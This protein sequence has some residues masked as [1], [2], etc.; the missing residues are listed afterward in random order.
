[1]SVDLLG[2]QVPGFFQLTVN[3]LLNSVGGHAHETCLSIPCLDSIADLEPPFPPVLINL[4]QGKFNA[5]AVHSK[6]SILPAIKLGRKRAQDLFKTEQL[7]KLVDLVD[8]EE[9]TRRDRIKQNPA[10]GGNSRRGQVGGVLTCASY[11]GA[12]AELSPVAFN[13]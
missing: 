13:R 10:R 5:L 11:G 12:W 2:G 8:E 3:L 6:P 1:M 9:P 4:L 7:L